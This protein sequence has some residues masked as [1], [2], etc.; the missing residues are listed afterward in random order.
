MLVMLR[1]WEEPGGCFQI[2]EGLCYG[3]GNDWGQEWGVDQG[4][5][6]QGYN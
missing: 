1:G 3:L 4:N 5:E 2:S 6:G